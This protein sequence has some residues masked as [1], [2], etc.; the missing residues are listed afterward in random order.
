MATA[1]ACK[2][3]PKAG[4]DIDQIVDAAQL[5]QDLDD[6]RIGRGEIFGPVASVI[7]AGNYEHA[8]VGMATVTYRRR[9]STRQ[10]SFSSNRTSAPC[11]DHP[12]GCG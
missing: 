9:A 2:S 10:H 6:I 7:P 4:I 5:E 1:M 3:A 12:D 11:N 8:Q